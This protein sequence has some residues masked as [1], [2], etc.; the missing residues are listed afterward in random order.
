VGS[1]CA[2]FIAIASSVRENNFSCEGVACANVGASIVMRS[3]S[4][5]RFRRLR[6]TRE[7][8]GGA[9]SG[10]IRTSPAK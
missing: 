5:V 10:S 9:F 2:T 1:S 4:W 6:I 7:G 3:V 8:A